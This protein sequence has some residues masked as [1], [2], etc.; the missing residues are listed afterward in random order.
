MKRFTRDFPC[1]ICGGFDR[2]PRGHGLRCFGF[3]SSDEEYCHCTRPE[4]AGPLTLDSAMTYAHRMKGDCRCGHPTQ[5]RP[6][7]VHFDKG[8]RDIGTH[9]R[10]FPQ[11]KRGRLVATY[12]Y[13]DAHGNPAHRTLRYA[14]P[15]SFSQQHY[16]NGQWK[17][18]LGDRPTYLYKLPDILSA[19]I[20][21]V[22]YLVEGEKDADA[23]SKRGMLASTCPMG[24]RHW[25]PNYAHWLRGRHVIILEDNDEQGYMRTCALAKHLKGVA[26]SLQAVQFLALPEGGDVSDWLE[27][28]GNP[29][30]LLSE[31][32]MYALPPLSVLVYDPIHAPWVGA[33]TH[34]GRAS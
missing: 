1:P 18:G 2:A 14:D 24:A 10:S 34:L 15:K 12:V 11:E 29:D 19:D 32:G 9:R 17:W 33:V 8:L 25:K 30:Y 5:N 4:K 3:L 13:T 6:E 26:A 23:L 28:G 20:R 22:V 7:R 16:E 21:R 31:L 27:K